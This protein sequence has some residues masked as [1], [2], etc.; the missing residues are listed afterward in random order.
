[1]PLL[2]ALVY[3]FTQVQYANAAPLILPLRRI[4]AV[5]KFHRS[6]HLRLLQRGGCIKLVQD[7]CIQ[8]AV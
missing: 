6:R 7:P 5:V 1:M 8:M 2:P 4:S 3:P